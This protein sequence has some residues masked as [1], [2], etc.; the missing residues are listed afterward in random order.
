MKT[1]KIALFKG[2]KVRKV[3]HQGEWWFS[4]VDVI[5]ALT[6]SAKNLFKIFLATEP[7]M[8]GLSFANLYLVSS[9]NSSR[10]F[11]I[12]PAKQMSVPLPTVWE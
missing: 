6:D 12:S 3:I 1:T 9:H 2:K 4:V 11:D 8:L 5:A 10:V 7:E